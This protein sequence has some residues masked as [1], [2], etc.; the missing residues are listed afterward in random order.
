VGAHLT[1]GLRN[2]TGQ[3]Q[4]LTSGAWSPGQEMDMRLEWHFHH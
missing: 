1:L 2:L 3:R 4:Q